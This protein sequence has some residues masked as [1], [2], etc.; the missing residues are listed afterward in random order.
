MSLQAVYKQFLAAPN[1][2]LLASNASLHYITTLVTI[3][4]SSEIIKHLNN[5]TRE[6]K[7]KEEKYLDVVEGADA[8]AVELHTTI[9]FVFGGGAYLPGLDDNF[10]ADRVVTF[11][12]VRIC[13]LVS[14]TALTFADPHGELRRRRQDSADPTKLGPRFSPEVDRCYW[15]DWTKLADPRWEGP[16]QV[17]CEQCQVSR[18]DYG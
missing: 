1:S 9:E 3:N 2:A 6:L 11:P 12:I 13:D 10:L 4:G 14:L 7:K 16:D 17:D 5:Q 8:L 15:Q 18:K